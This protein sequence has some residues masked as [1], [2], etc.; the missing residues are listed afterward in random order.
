M[1]STSTAT[2]ATTATIFA[3]QSEPLF[4][5]L[6]VV[7]PG[8]ELQRTAKLFARA[9]RIM[10]AALRDGTPCTVAQ[11]LAV[12]IASKNED[13]THDMPEMVNALMLASSLA[14]R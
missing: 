5:E 13:E 14:N 3:T 8:D 1:E 11:A 2:T 9:A 4:M 7:N 12:A 6:T 10:E